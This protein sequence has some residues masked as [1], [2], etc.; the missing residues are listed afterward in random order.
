MQELEL[1]LRDGWPTAAACLLGSIA[2]LAGLR[3]ALHR[4]ELALRDKLVVVLA[5]GGLA[6]AGI[7]PQLLSSPQAMA[8][9]LGTLASEHPL[10]LAGAALALALAFIA[11]LLAWWVRFWVR[12][13]LRFVT[14]CAFVI[15]LSV[16]AVARFF[17]A[18]LFDAWS[19][20]TLGADGWRALLD[21]AGVTAIVVAVLR[22]LRAGPPKEREA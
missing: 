4:T 1:L 3:S 13:M 17:F 20:L 10:A 16:W 7:A 21:G 12:T 18:D 11:V 19:G 15:A 5:A 8:A 6:T 2:L 14:L 22:L 9:Q